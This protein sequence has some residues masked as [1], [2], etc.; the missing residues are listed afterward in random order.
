MTD[1]FELLSFSSSHSIYP[2]LDFEDF[3]IP[4]N[5]QQT[6]TL[7]IN[8]TLENSTTLGIEVSEEKQAKQTYDVK[9]IPSIVYHP[10]DR[11]N[12]SLMRLSLMYDV[13]ISQ[14]KMANG[15]LSGDDD[16]SFF[17]EEFIIIPGPKR[18]PL[19]IPVGK[20]KE[21]IEEEKRKLSIRY[22]QGIKHVNLDVAKCYLALSDYNLQK[23]VK[24][25][26]ADIAWENQEKK[27]KE[28]IANVSKKQNLFEFLVCCYKKS[29]YILLKD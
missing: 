28:L 1:N 4:V 18:L 27:K 10:F 16:L 22:F 5:Y 7:E 21:E 11:V 20:V 23:A 24:E 14:I 26:E 6:Q 19:H 13:E 25:Y 29:Q 15:I 8:P 2:T 12:D 17:E 3:S 9:D